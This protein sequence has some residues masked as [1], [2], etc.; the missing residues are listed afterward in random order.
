M[1]AAASLAGGSLVRLLIPLLF[2]LCLF[3]FTAVVL[4]VIGALIG[5]GPLMCGLK[6]QGKKKLGIIGFIVCLVT[7]VAIGLIPGLAVSL[8]FTF[9]ILKGVKNEE[10]VIEEAAAEEPATEE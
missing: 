8:L 7:Y 9:L 6:I 10:P 2:V 5:A 3:V 1:D 4:L